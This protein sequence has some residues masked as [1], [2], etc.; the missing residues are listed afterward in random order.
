VNDL[1]SSETSWPRYCTTIETRGTFFAPKRVNKL[2]GSR[3][4][5]LIL[6]TLIAGFCDSQ[7]SLCFS[8]SCLSV[9]KM[10]CSFTALLGT[11]IF[12]RL[13]LP[14]DRVILER[15]ARNT[16]ENARFTKAI[17]SPKP[18]QRWLL[19]TS[20][21]HM[22]RAVSLFR[23]VG[24]PVEP[25][26]VDWMTRGNVDLVKFFDRPVDALLRTDIGVREWIGLSAN[27]LVG[28]STDFFPRNR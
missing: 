10:R 14:R 4:T 8:A 11:S 24:F 15:E 2:N 20:A 7:R 26:P 19:I 27:W 17:A 9:P 18:G 25:Y 21:Y 28:N 5:R 23:E 12:G 13:G 16:I 22:P 3:F 6:M 1:H